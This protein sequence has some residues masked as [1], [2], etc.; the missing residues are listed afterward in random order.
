[1]RA[2]FIPDRDR[3]QFSTRKV[4]TRKEAE[5]DAPPWAIRF[6]RVMGGFMAF[7][8]QAALDEW[9]ARAERLRAQGV[10]V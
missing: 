1:M 8:S 2:V 4:S 7:D 5:Q 10:A 3:K 6:A 9:L